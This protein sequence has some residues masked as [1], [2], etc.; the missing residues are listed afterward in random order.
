MYAVH[1]VTRRTHAP[2]ESDWRSTK[3]IVQYLKGTIDLKLRI[4]VDVSAKTLQG[5]QL[6][7]YSDADY[8]ADRI[9]RKSISGGVLCVDGI[10]V[11]WFCKK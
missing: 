9:D 1:R 2:R 3:Q 6:E 8:A 5:V 11:G 4:K 10:V 7:G